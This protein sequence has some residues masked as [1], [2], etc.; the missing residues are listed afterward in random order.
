VLISWITGF[1]RNPL[2]LVPV[3]SV[4]YAILDLLVRAL[5]VDQLLLQEHL[6]QSHRTSPSLDHR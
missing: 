2:V 3:V 4:V 5:P 6:R 1:L